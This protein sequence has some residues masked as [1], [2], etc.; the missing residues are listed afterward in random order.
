MA[1]RRRGDTVRVEG[2]YQYAAVHSGNPVQQFWHYAKYSEA[3][4]WLDVRP[5]HTVLDVGCGSGVLSHSVAANSPDARVIGV[6]VSE[7]AIEFCRER[8]DLPN[9]EFQLG[10]VDELEFEPGSIDRIALLEVIEHVYEHQALRVLESFHRLLR[11]DGRLVISTPNYRS[12]WPLIELML[13]KLKLVPQLAGEQHVAKYTGRKLL[14][15]AHASGFKSVSLR[16]VNWIAPWLNVFSRRL[17][18]AV[19]RAEVRFEHNAG[20]VLLY[21]FEKDGARLPRR[22]G[23]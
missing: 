10:L 18:E 14:R 21:S 15:L 22:A 2:E 12:L 23:T 7:A 9:L 13:D 17:A 16:S 19:H 11:A 1:E 3:E 20:S 6:D 5:G 8:Y 4:R